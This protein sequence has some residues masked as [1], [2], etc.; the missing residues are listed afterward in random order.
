MNI[1][2]RM[3]D[4]VLGWAATS[5]GPAALFMLAFFESSFFPIPPDPLLIAL[6]LGART[7]AF[8]F[9]LI[10]SVASVAGSLLGYAIGYYSWWTA[11]GEFTALARFFFNTVPGFTLEKFELVQGLF[12]R[13]NFW[14]VFT[15]GFTPLPF[16]VFTISG[17]A[18]DI[19]LI[20]FVLASMIGRSARFFGVA[21]L[22]WRFGPRITY[23]IDR[24]FNWLA[25]LFTILLI[26]GFV[27][28]KAF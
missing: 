13:W 21:W 14:I 25:I 28:L 22:I 3:Y 11:S 1:V 26:G 6:I 10:C 7:K 9:A 2:R 5:S 18:F 27:L 24:Y 16:K 17:G 23:F 15:A 19:S 20:P 8:R 12:E 4:W